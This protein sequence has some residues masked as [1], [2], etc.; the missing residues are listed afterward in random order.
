MFVEQD[1]NS[2]EQIVII[3]DALARRVFSNEEAVGKRL[4]FEPRGPSKTIIGIAANVKNNPGLAGAD[5]PEY[6]VLRK[7]DDA[8]DASRQAAVIIRTSSTPAAASSAIRGTVAAIDASLP[9]SVYTLDQRV[10]ELAAVPRFNATLFGWFAVIGVSL[11]AVGLYGV[12]SF[13]VAQRI[14]EIGIRLALGATPEN[15][16]GL[17]FS[18]ALRWTVSGIAA[19]LVGAAFAARVLRTLLFQISE[20][21]PWTLSLTVIIMM[22]T[23]LLA[24]WLPA[25]HASRT[26]PMIVLRQE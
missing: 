13:L 10:H 7:H 16:L 14:Q 25:S 8:E 15:I 3:S 12:V 1:R 26:D 21:D 4:R 20:Y 19:G 24:A 6:Y 18:M 9:V 11:A 17:V 2:Q 23:A 22:A 5:D